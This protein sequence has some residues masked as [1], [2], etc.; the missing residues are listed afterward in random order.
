[1][2]ASPIAAAAP[3]FAYKLAHSQLALRASPADEPAV[4]HIDWSDTRIQLPAPTVSLTNAFTGSTVETATDEL[5]V[6]ELLR[7]FSDAHAVLEL[8][9]NFRSN[10]RGQEETQIRKEGE[11]RSR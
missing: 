5:P 9:C 1:M 11:R 3:R 7:D 4:C 8:C 6:G 10:H 2:N